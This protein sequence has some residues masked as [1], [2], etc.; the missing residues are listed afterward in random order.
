MPRLFC[1]AA[2][3]LGAVL[4]PAL[5]AAG[6]SPPG[7][8]VTAWA[9]GQQ[10]RARLIAGR[11]R[12]G[13]LAAGV[14]I[15]LPPGWKTYWRSP[16]EAGGVPPEFGWRGSANL[17]GADVL[18]P[19]PERMVDAAGVTYGYHGS[20][21]FPVMVRPEEPGRSVDLKL[22]LAYGICKDICIPNG[23]SLALSIPAAEVP[24]IP[25]ALADALARVP[26]PQ[27]A[28]GPLDPVLVEQHRFPAA[29]G[30][31]RLTLKV[32]FPGGTDGVLAILDGP[33]GL[34]LPEP[35]KIAEADG[36][37]TFSAVLSPAET[38]LLAG[39]PA[40]LTLAGPGGRTAA[41]ARL[42]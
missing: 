32:R 34:Y 19:V 28:L 17:A 23:L 36:I 12:D 26:R 6:G 40:T 31:L 41:E 2:A 24:E 20:V 39:H 27:G 9:A 5:A 33:G 13:R 3:F 4:L 7:P 22:A 10:S 18:Y 42:D 1:L 30:S 35:G 29:D 11:T 25:D 21:V 38:A 8:L 37:V 16:G 14:E 15:E